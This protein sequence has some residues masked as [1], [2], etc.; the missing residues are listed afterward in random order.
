MS[1][2]A[3][4]TRLPV[5]AAR[6]P[7]FLLLAAFGARAWARMVEPAASGAVVVALLAALAGG[8]VL[9]AVA[10]RRPRRGGRAV[11]TV[12]V[13]VVMLL[14]AL[15]AADV[16][17][18]VRPRSWDHVAAGIGQGLSAVPG[19]RVPYRGVDEWT[20]IVIVL[21]CVALLV[22]ATLLA[23]APRRDGALGF[24]IAAA[25]ALGTLYTVPTMQHA[26]AHPFLA[27]AAFAL[28]LALFL[29]LERVERRSAPIA[30][31]VVAAAILVALVAAPRLD[32]AGAL[33]DYERIAQSLGSTSTR[34]DWNHVYGPLSWPRDGHEVLRVGARDRAYWKAADLTAFDG[35]RWVQSPRAPGQDLDRGLD[36]VHSR[37]RQTL[38]VSVRGLISSQFVAAGTTLGLAG[39]PRVSSRRATRRLSAATPTAPSCTRRAPPRATCGRRRAARCRSA[40]T[41]RR[42]SCRRPGVVRASAPGSSRSRRGAAAPRRTPPSPRSRP[43]RTAP[44]TTSR[45]GCARARRAPTSS[46]APSS[47]T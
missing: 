34:Y 19:V 11:A 21:G 23:F 13:A 35:R 12:L 9:A 42:S 44:P 26:G 14:L 17:D 16:P 22:V 2:A 24:P 30:A 8:A 7:A 45:G 31:G 41:R 10:R 27:G 5:A 4:E 28:L 18:L 43:R 20:R 38:R 6:L 37:W 47:A 39:T 29:W 46:C 15:A 33:L 36:G 25:V 40:R 32:G 1:A 3:A